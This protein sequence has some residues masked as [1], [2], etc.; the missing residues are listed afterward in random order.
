M[1]MDNDYKN[2][3]PTKFSNP[4]KL[5]KCRRRTVPNQRGVLKSP[6]D[7]RFTEGSDIRYQYQFL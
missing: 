4:N 5:Q 2:H 1:E 3:T 6:N 7:V